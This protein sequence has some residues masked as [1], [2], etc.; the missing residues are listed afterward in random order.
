MDPFSKSFYLPSDFNHSNLTHAIVDEINSHYN[1]HVTIQEEFG[2]AL[3][4]TTS[5]AV[6]EA[7]V[8]GAADIT[9]PNFSFAGTF[10]GLQRE[11]EPL[12]QHTC[13]SNT[14]LGTVLVPQG[15]TIEDIHNTTKIKMCSS[16]A[17][18]QAVYQ[19]AFGLPVFSYDQALTP[20]N[21]ALLNFLLS[22]PYGCNAW[23]DSL[24]SATIDSNLFDGTESPG[25][26]AAVSALYEDFAAPFVSPS[27]AFAK[28]W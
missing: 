20:N 6:M 28:C 25:A 24:L 21:G 2:T 11:Y 18:T 12:I 13:A 9:G 26:V 15:T 8:S 27:G 4:G 14:I 10:R 1:T 16:G 7:V 3:S 19:A 5:N 23:P 22:N 17:G